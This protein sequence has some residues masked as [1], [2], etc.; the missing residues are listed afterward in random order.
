[1]RILGNG[2]SERRSLGTTIEIRQEGADKEMTKRNERKKVSEGWLESHGW[3]DSHCVWRCL[4]LILL[5]QIRKG[6][7]QFRRKN[8]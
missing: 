7:A 3:Y 6:N 1:M 8:A 4:L 2:R 5:L